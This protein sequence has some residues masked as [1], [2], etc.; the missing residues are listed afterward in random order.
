MKSILRCRQ[1]YARHDLINQFKA[2]VLCLIE[3]NVGGIY[4]ACDSHLQKLDSMQDDFIEELEICPK[5]AFM[6][7]NFAPLALRRD[8][9]MLGLLHKR[10]RGIAH[11]HFS[12]LFPF[13]E[14]QT[15]PGRHNK[16]L[17]SKQRD[18][19]HFQQCLFQRS[20]FHLTLAYNRL[21]QNFIDIESISEFQ[22]EL[23]EVVKARCS[24]DF[25][26]ID[27]FSPRNPACATC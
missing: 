23:T 15:R 17:V 5:K 10:V 26:W 25:S 20:L 14:N 19:M 21:P 13:A 12:K 9:A 3:G 7:Y 27:F 18:D 2:H 22:H 11:E 6:E 4:H 24:A 1:Y 8:I 16:Q